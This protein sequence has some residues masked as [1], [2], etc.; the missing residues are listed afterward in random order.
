[1]FERFYVTPVLDN[2]DDVKSMIIVHG[3]KAEKQMKNNVIIMDISDGDTYDDAFRRFK[4][5]VDK[6]GWKKAHKHFRW[7][8]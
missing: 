7:Y 1:M 8:K 5:C 4:T 3:R 6:V 2:N